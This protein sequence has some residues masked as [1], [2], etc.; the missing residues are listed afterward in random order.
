MIDR[1]KVVDALRNCINKPKCRNC[2]WEECEDINHEKVS[3]P[4]GLVMDIFDLL[5]SEETVPLKPLVVWL[6]RYAAPPVRLGIDC[7]MG[8]IEKAWEIVLRGMK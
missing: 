4:K 7:T 2:Y 8:D 5:K 6:A 1:D 3:L